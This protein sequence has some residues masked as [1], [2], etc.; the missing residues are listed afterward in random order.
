MTSHGK[1]SFFQKT[2][3]Q[4][5]SQTDRS[6]SSTKRHKSTPNDC[7]KVFCLGFF[8]WSLRSIIF[9]EYKIAQNFLSIPDNG[10]LIGWTGA[11]SEFGHPHSSNMSCFYRVVIYVI[12]QE[13]DL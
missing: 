2:D 8:N 5:D 1:T 9:F 13:N 10:D 3:K 6:T 4:Q 7:P 11:V 12:T